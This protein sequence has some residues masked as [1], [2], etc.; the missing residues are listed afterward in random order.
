MKASVSL[1]AGVFPH[2]P[3]E[4]LQILPEL[5]PPSSF[6]PS[7]LPFSL[8]SELQISMGISGPQLP[9][10]NCELQITVGTA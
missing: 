7:V 8:N 5:L 3:G 4:G 9:D 6:L 1:R 10:L 2:L